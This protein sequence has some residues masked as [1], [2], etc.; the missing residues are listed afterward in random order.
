MAHMPTTAERDAR[1]INARHGEI[2]AGRDRDR[3]RHRP[4]L[5]VLRFL[6]LRDRIGDRVSQARLSL[7]RSAAGTLYSFAIFALAFVARPIGTW[8][9]M[10]VDR[11]Y[12]KS[13]KLTIALFLLG[14]STVAIAFLP[15]YGQIGAASIWLLACAHRP[16]HR[17][18]RHLG[19]AGL[20]AGPERPEQ[21]SRLVCDDPAARRAARADRGQRAV[22]LLR[23]Q[24][25]GRGFLQL[26]LAL[27]V[28]RRLRH[29]R[30]GPVRPAAHGGDAGLPKA[31]R[32]PRAAADAIPRDTLRAKGGTS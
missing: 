26:G 21:I 32:E 20:A 13:A 2:D 29:Q 4:D 19:R 22:R 7:S 18:R 3:R 24:S 28:L 5:R 1:I 11:A 6:R 23:R 16:G 25:L 9:F 30:R 15:G 12:G 10:A 17:A 27:P 14:T 8:I 31:V